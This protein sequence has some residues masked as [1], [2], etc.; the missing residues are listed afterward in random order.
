MSDKTIDVRLKQRYDT[1]ANWNSANPVL[2]EGEMAISSDKN[3]KY[4]V[5]NGTSTWKQLNYAKS[6]LQKSDVVNALGYTPPTTNTTYTTGTA[7]KAG[8]TKLYPETGIHTDGTM[9][10]VAITDALDGKAAASHSHDADEI[11]LPTGTNGV[12]YNNNGDIAVSTVTYTELGYL[13]GVTSNIQTQLNGKAATGHT[14]N[15]AGS[16]SSGGSANSAVKL[17]TSAGSATQPVYFSGGKPAA[18]TYTLAKSVP[19][20]AKF[21]DTNTWIALKGSTSESAGTAGYA[22]APAAGNSNRYLRCDG[23]W[24]V[25]PDTNTTYSVFKAASSSAGGGTGLVPAP[26]AG[27]A[28]RYLRS[29]GTW[30]VPSDTNTTYTLSSFGITATASELNYM[31]GVTSNVQTQLNG[32]SSSGHTHSIATISSSGFMSASDKSKLDGITIMGGCTSSGAGKSGLVPAPSAGYQ[33]KYLRGDATWGGL[34][35]T[36]GDGLMSKSH[37]TQINNLET[38]VNQLNT[39]MNNM[40]YFKK[41]SYSPI[42]LQANKTKILTIPLSGLSGKTIDATILTLRGG[43]P[44]MS[45]INYIYKDS[46][47]VALRAADDLE[48]RLIE[49][50]I[51]YH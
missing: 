33:S 34:A 49:L 15:Y 16:G 23:T 50:Y 2:L 48:N 10:Q 42:S 21:T 6:D 47:E 29:D 51:F 35:S 22:P 43:V 28:N 17:D 19:S 44:Y 46:I 3:G 30:S 25:P 5:G 31:D 40:R 20:D 4:K 13:D 45:S 7:T 11:I 39:N 14:H 1:E 37:V 9:T 18:C 36:S 12:L 24:Q 38:S 27:S 26:S 8:I 32:K 41:I